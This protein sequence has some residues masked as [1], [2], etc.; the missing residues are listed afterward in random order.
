MAASLFLSSS[1]RLLPT[2][3]VFA[4]TRRCL[5]ASEITT[6]LRP[7]Y[8]L[9]HPDL[10]GRFPK[11]RTINENSIQ[12]LKCFVDDI[13]KQT[14]GTRSTT[15]KFYLRPPN[16]FS[17][18]DRSKLK[19]VTIRL[20]EGDVRKTILKVL[21]QANLPTSFVDSI[22]IK[23]KASS[24]FTLLRDDVVGDVRYHGHEVWICQANVAQDGR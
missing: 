2:S 11:E 14:G 23:Q 22:P 6:A 18:R 16:V 17:N 5:T 9:V 13:A 1:S 19:L 20:D 21:R 15:L 4:L 10:F 3:N 12:T 8:F 24:S 7:F